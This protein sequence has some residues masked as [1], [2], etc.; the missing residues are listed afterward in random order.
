[1]TTDL[2]I[3]CSYC[4]RE[5]NHAVQR[6][7][8]QSHNSEDSFFRS[9]Y[10]I[11]ECK[12]CNTVSF[13]EEIGGSDYYNHNTNE[14]EPEVYL[15]PRRSEKTRNLKYF[16]NAPTSLSTLYREVIDA[17][18]ADMSILC[19]GG[20]RALVEGIALDKGIAGGDVPKDAKNSA[21]GTIYRDNLQGKIAGMAQKNI[22]TEAHAQSLHEHRF[23]G[24]EALHQLK[25]PG[26]SG[27]EAAI[28][29]IEHT[30]ENIYELPEKARRIR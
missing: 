25:K 5:T 1:M 17:Y 6:E 19:A 30:M 9:T 7:Y 28:D 23:L 12:G 20:L 21:A 18:N 26:A 3:F 29:V 10:Q 22:L 24:N 13:R 2:R 11:V 15:Y 16:W 4:R 14:T 8:E 27:L